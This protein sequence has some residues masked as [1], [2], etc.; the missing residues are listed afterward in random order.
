MEV[1][2][3]IAYNH[4][5]PNELRKFPWSFGTRLGKFRSVRIKAKAIN[6]RLMGFP[7]LPLLLFIKLVHI[8][9][10]GAYR[11][12]FFLKRYFLANEKASIYIIMFINI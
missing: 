10:N 3:L 2:R 1:K 6:R 11:K 4:D 5:H 8:R 12:I 7:G 9:K